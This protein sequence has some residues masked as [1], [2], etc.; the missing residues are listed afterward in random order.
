MIAK[1]FRT[2]HRL[3]VRLAL[4]GAGLCL[5]TLPANA[6]PGPYDQADTAG[7]VSGVTVY[8]PHRYARQPTTGAIVRMDS[9]SRVVEL[10]DLDL[11]TR[12]GA[13]VAKAR[14]SWAARAVCND[15]EDA[16]PRDV[17]APGSCYMKAVRQGLAQAQDMAG[18]PI[19]AWGYR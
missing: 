15:V 4:A 3:A 14:I 10:G 1:H 8:G 12:Y 18:Y 11:S 6:Q 17:Q 9:V 5:P 19:V 16:Y 13:H 7:A 2:A